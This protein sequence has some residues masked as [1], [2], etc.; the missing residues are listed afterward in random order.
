MALPACDIFDLGAI[1]Q[2]QVTYTSPTTAVVIHDGGN[3][4]DNCVFDVMFTGGTAVGLALAPPAGAAAVILSWALFGGETYKTLDD[5][6]VSWDQVVSPNLGL[7][8]LS[9]YCVFRYNLD[10]YD[11][12]ILRGWALWTEMQAVNSAIAAGALI[13]WTAL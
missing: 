9:T 7:R 11:N 5:C 4:A 8:A 1:R 13:G 12:C 3:I 10:H 2:A 6:L